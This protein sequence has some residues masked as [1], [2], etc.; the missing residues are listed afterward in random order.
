MKTKTNDII[1][2]K[3]QK[4]DAMGGIALWIFQNLEWLDDMIEKETFETLLYA[5]CNRQEIIDETDYLKF[6]ICV[7]LA[8][9][10]EDRIFT[11][12][13]L[14]KGG[15]ERYQYILDILNEYSIWDNELVSN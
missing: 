4:M 15:E 3:V 11:P 8:I 10:L 9:Y 14:Q 6:W 13:Y 2:E 7:Q 1:I 12:N 5:I